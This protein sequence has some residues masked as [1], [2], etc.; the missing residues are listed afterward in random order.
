VFLGK[1]NY[2]RLLRY[3]PSFAKVRM[4]AKALYAL[5]LEYQILK[6]ASS[7][8][9]GVSEQEDEDGSEG[10]PLLVQ[11]Y[12]DLSIPTQVFPHGAFCSSHARVPNE[13]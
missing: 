3:P 5:A 6:T 10:K 11:Q 1:I 4:A 2:V 12:S 7:K 9:S 8:A 13:E